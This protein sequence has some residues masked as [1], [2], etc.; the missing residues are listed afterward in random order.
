MRGG[1]KLC[2]EGERLCERRKEDEIRGREGGR[3][4]RRETVRG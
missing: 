2:E 3:W 4:R 1:T